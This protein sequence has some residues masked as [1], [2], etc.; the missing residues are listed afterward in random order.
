MLVNKGWTKK[1]G[2]M[3]YFDIQ[4]QRNGT[5]A[6]KRHASRKTHL[7]GEGVDDVDARADALGEHHAGDVAQVA[8][9]LLRQD[10]QVV[11]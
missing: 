11:L 2:N 9:Q 5:T 1:K 7:S 4:Y 10:Q 3:Y 6:R 8:G